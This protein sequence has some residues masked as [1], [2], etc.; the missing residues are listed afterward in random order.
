MY[1]LSGQVGQKRVTIGAEDAQ[2]DK[3]PI[4]E[5]VEVATKWTTTGV[6]ATGFQNE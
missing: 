2:F 5:L 3:M 6:Q 4:S 1:G